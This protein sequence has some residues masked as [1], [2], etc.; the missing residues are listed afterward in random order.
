MKQKN[1]HSL[2]NRHIKTNKAHRI[3]P[4]NH[5]QIPLKTRRNKYII[6]RNPSKQRP[7][8]LFTDKPRT[9]IINTPHQGVEIFAVYTY[10]LSDFCGKTNGSPMAHKRA[11]LNEKLN[12]TI[13][14]FPVVYKDIHLCLSVFQVVIMFTY[15]F[16]YECLLFLKV[17]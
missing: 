11:S 5:H 15:Q 16:I 6:Q 1:T 13:N 4:S 2:K 7:P 3:T 8:R 12:D 14:L 17:F 10:T 9:Y